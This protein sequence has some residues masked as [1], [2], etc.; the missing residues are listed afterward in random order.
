MS[1]KGGGL[2]NYVLVDETKEA[3]LSLF[4]KISNT[5][6]K[7]QTNPVKLEAEV[8]QYSEQLPPL[9]KKLEE[10]YWVVTQATNY[11]VVS[12]FIVIVNNESDKYKKLKPK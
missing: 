5:E 11:T 2:H 10:N 1:I 6:E 7:H 3:I 12:E 4:D 8:E 9:Y